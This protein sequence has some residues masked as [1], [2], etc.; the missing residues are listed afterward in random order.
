MTKLNVL[1]G[2]VLKLLSEVYP[3]GINQTSLLGVY[4]D[5]NRVDDI[6]QATQYLVDKEYV[7]RKETPHPYKSSEK[8]VYFKIL[9]AGIDL[10]EGNVEQDS[11]I[12]IPKEA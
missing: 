5:Y 8:V 1:R 7:E 9:P 10:I 4:H 6:I 2:Q 11:G 3:D 12:L